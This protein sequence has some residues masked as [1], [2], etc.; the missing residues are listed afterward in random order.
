MNWTEI[1]LN[2]RLDRIP[3]LYKSRN[4]GQDPPSA[5]DGLPALMRQTWKEGDWMQWNE[6]M[7]LALY[8]ITKAVAAI[9][10]AVF[11]EELQDNMEVQMEL[12]RNVLEAQ[13]E[14]AEW[15]DQ[16]GLQELHL[17]A[18]KTCKQR[19]LELD[20]ELLLHIQKIQSYGYHLEEIYEA[21]QL[22]ILTLSKELA[23]LK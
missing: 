6:R 20:Q 23:L 9:E 15:I 19:F 4:G 11:C 8:T 17:P 16:Y 7:G 12:M 10:H 21:V 5:G 2:R 18:V 1:Y 13:T 3:I 22:E 14:T